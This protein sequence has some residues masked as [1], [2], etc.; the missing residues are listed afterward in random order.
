MKRC[1]DFEMNHREIL[2]Q[3]TVRIGQ[4]IWLE[5]EIAN[6]DAASEPF[7]EFCRDIPERADHPLFAA[8][9]ALARFAD[10]EDWPDIEEVTEALFFANVHQGFIFQAEHPVKT[11]RSETSSSYSWGYY[12]TAWLFA[13]SLDG[14]ASA[15]AAWA[16]K[17]DEESRQ[18]QLATA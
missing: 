7:R 2:E 4:I 17:I 13:D 15:A 14:V 6:F 5:N 10:A 3:A 18:K 12:N 1:G 8:L 9:P 11:W 16:E